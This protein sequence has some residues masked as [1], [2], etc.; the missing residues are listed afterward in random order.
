MTK[1]IELMELKAFITTTKLQ[2]KNTWNV[3]NKG[4]KSNEQYC[5]LS[6]I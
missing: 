6:N 3:T 4:I 2:K 1:E 5:L